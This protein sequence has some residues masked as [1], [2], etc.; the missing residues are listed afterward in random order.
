MLD[1][2]S[3][4]RLHTRSTPNQSSGATMLWDHLEAGPYSGIVDSNYVIPREF[5]IDEFQKIVNAFGSAA[6]RASHTGLNMIETH[7]ARGYLIL[8]SLS[9]VSN[10]RA[11]RYDGSL[12]NQT[13]LLIEIIHEVRSNFSAEKSI[14]VHISASDNLEYLNDRSS[15]YEIGICDTGVDV[16]RDVT[17]GDSSAL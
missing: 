7:G 11:D 5:A 17:L 16:P 9:P 2:R 8:Q 12:E 6:T 4:P 1:A 15:S 10:K 13:L 14:F 3:S